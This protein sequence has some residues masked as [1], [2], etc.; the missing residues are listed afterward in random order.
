MRRPGLS[1]RFGVRGQ[2]GLSQI[3]QSKQEVEK[4][5]ARFARPTAVANLDLIP[6]GSRPLDPTELLSGPRMSELVAWAETVYDQ[7]LIDCPPV[8]AASDA[9]IVGRYAGNMLMVIQ[10]AKNHRRIVLRA[11]DE[12]I[13]MG[14]NLTGF[15]VNRV[16]ED[17]HGDFA[18]YGYEDGYY[19]DS[20]EED[21]MENQRSSPNAYRKAA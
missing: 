11:V 9:G 10:P 20:D 18:G 17:A 6:F 1:K 13:R 4:A 12:L 15:V 7:I 21:Q 5:A 14:V 8:L 2:Q 16:G 3:L 19:E